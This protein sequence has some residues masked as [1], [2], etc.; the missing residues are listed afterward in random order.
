MKWLMILFTL[1]SKH[2][3][4][5]SGESHI[6][7]VAEMKS[8]VQENAVKVLL[9][10]ILASIMS[11]LFVAGMVITVV[12]VSSLYDQGLPIIF[13]AMITSGIAMSSVSLLTIVI[14]YRSL[15]KD[16]RTVRSQ[17]TQVPHP[18]ALQESLLMLVNDFVKERE[19]NRT[20]NSQNKSRPKTNMAAQ[21]GT[22]EF[23]PIHDA[24]EVAS[25]DKH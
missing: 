4:S 19:F 21:E 10:F 2:F 8:F 3:F 18:T 15:S 5:S 14:V 23:D 24:D 13:N 9:G 16:K 7:P 1:F 17:A 12:G 11:S 22:S 6:N 25:F 20:V